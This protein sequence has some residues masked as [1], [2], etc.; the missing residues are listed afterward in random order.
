MTASRENATVQAWMTDPRS[1]KSMTALRRIR[2]NS[3]PPFAAT[4]LLLASAS[5]Q[6]ADSPRV[7]SGLQALYTFEEGRGNTVQDRSGVTP[8]LN[9]QIDKTSGVQWRDGV[10][11]VRSSTRIRSSRPGKKIVDAVK[12]TNALTIEAWVK[13]G[14]NRQAGP[15][16]I[17]SLSAGPNQRDLTLGQ[18]GKRYDVRLRTKSTSANGIPSTAGP[19]NG[20]TTKLTHVVYTRDA[21]GN[22]RLY[23]DGQQRASKKVAGELSNWSDKFQLSLA[24]E[25]TGSR[26]WLGELH[27]VAI[28]SRAL[29]AEEVGKNFA[30]G[31]RGS[32]ST[33]VA[34]ADPS[35]VQRVRGGLTA[36][37]TFDAGQGDSV[38]DQSP[39]DPP[40]DLKIA[41][42]AA[43]QW[44]DG[45]LTVRSSTRILSMQPATKISDAIKRS[46]AATIEA[47]VTPGNERQ[48]GPARIVS[49]S[50]DTGQRNFTLGQEGQQ[51]DVRWRTGETGGNGLP[52]T[53]TPSDTAGTQRTHLVFTRDASGNLRI[54]INGEQQS[55]RKV[56]GNL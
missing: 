45:S 2:R 36:L 39:A 51:F 56:S 22:A 48:G 25:T 3:L 41:E 16:R 54:Y 10:L 9:L 24:N 21:A 4:L 33:V 7:T 52:S 12:R 8:Q 13:P 43:V 37:Y 11:V 17:V 29:T 40:L 44:R 50:A 30:A 15:A 27:L 18:D 5:S 1:V 19:D 35:A 55:S 42:P 14:S 49:F 23:G 47:W 46:G 53:A 38:P 32:A 34:T 28:Y 31:S 20:A 26:P 6:A